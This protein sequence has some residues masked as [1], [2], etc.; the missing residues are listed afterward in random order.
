MEENKGSV[1]NWYNNY[2]GSQQKIGINIRHRTILKKAIVE[3][4]KKDSK[5]LEIGCGVG[6]LTKLL[7]SHVTKGK[8][9][10]VDISD[11]SI[12]ESTKFLSGYNNVECIVNDMSNFSNGEKYDFVILPDVMEHIPVEQHNN[13]FRV[14]SE[15]THENSRILIN[16]PHPTFIEWLRIHEPALMQI[17]D[18]PIHSDELCKNAYEH[19]YILASLNSY[20][21][22]HQDPDYQFIVFKK[23]VA[24][25]SMV[26]KSKIILK[27]EDIKSKL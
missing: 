11:E 24:Y 3:G 27:K 17:I 16:V 9:S 23:N 10:A 21:L 2:V 8:I 19:G 14:L 7:C 26:K 4:L 25:Q 5:V 15:H 12:K 1:K 20:C 13:L 6:T 22:Y 18:Q